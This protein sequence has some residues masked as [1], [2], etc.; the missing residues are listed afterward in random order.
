MKEFLDRVYL[1]NT[2]REYLWAIGVILLILALHRLIARVLATI[3]SRVLR[4]R[5]STLNETRFL[6]L[7]VRPLGAFL[8]VSVIIMVLYKLTFPSL[9]NFTLYKYPLHQI[10]ISLGKIFQIAVFIWLLLRVIDFIA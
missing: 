7:I 1:D 5:W 4:R 10:F 6:D 2:V 8:L 3:T 9:L